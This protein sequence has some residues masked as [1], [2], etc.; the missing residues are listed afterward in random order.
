M[1]RDDETFTIPEET[2]NQPNDVLFEADEK[3]PSP[4]APAWL[5]FT[6]ILAAVLGGMFIIAHIPSLKR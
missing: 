3:E 6:V 4:Y 1:N 5:I 2:R